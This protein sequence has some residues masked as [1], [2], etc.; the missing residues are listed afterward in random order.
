[1]HKYIISL[2]LLPILGCAQEKQLKLLFIGDIMGH[3]SQIAAAYN[4]DE[5]RYEYDTVFSY[6]K[7]IMQS[8]DYCVA[9]LEVTLAGPPFKGYPQFSSPDALA[10]SLKKAGV[11]C[12]VTANNHSCDRGKTGVER[13]IKVLDSLQ[14]DHTGTFIDQAE[15]DTTQPLIIKR[16]GISVAMLNYTYGTNGL[17]PT[18]P[19]VVNY[20]RLDDIKRDLQKAKKLDVDKVLV[21][22]H[23]GIQYEM[24]PREDQEN[25]YK[26]CI[27]NGADYVIG[28]HPHVLQK[29]EKHDE[30]L[31]VYSLGN[32]V[33]NQRTFPR[34]GGAMF[35]LTLGKTDDSTFIVPAKTGYYLTWVYPPVIGGKKYFFVLPAQQFEDDSNFITASYKAKMDKWLKEMRTLLREENLELHEM[36]YD[37]KKQ[38]W[39]PHIID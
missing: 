21:F 30:H 28:S 22:F 33:S 25:L 13:T 15:K 37:R 17:A 2:V 29:M 11:D 24:Q 5:D 8:A 7:P 26:I 35:Q 12:L 27:D 38:S 32:F 10:V 4:P 6:V 34:D 36:Q 16:N 18:A 39:S 14:I 20:I 3:D 31:V 19:N 23:W 9:N 1:M